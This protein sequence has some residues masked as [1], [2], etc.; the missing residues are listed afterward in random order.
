VLLFSRFAAAGHKN[1][2]YQVCFDIITAFSQKDHGRLSNN[3]FFIPLVQAPIVAYAPHCILGKWDQL[4]PKCDINL[5][6]CTG[7]SCSYRFSALVV[8]I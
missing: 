2:V 6:K 8:L 1:A 5:S 3:T 7:M 4:Y